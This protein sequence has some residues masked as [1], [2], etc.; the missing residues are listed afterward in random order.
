MIVET[1]V[2][3]EICILGRLCDAIDPNLFFVGKCC[4]AYELS[5]LGANYLKDK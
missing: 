4:S 1:R 2:R 3:R 5:D